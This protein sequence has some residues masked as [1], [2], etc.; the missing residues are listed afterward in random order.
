MTRG[1]LQ[2]AAIEEDLLANEV[3]ATDGIKGF[4]SVLDEFANGTMEARLLEVLSCNGCIAGPRAF[5]RGDAVQAARPGQPLRPLPRLPAGPR[6][7]AA[8]GG[9]L[10]RAWT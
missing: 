1:F 6:R 3:V 4:T 5:Q 9:Q 7:M 2:A 10:R 8:R